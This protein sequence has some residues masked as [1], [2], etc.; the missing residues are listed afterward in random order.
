MLDFGVVC[1]CVPATKN[2]GTGARNPS[3]ARIL[4]PTNMT[5]R[6]ADF[7]P[8]HGQIVGSF[9]YI[10]YVVVILAFAAPNEIFVI[11]GVLGMLLYVAAKCC[12][13]SMGD[14]HCPLVLRYQ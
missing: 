9:Y 8:V 11:R 12:T 2:P 10:D 6:L 1:S 5:E 13:S 7:S 4:M 3:T 14:A